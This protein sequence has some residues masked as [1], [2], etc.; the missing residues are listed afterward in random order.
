MI[1]NTSNT[2]KIFKGWLEQRPP[3]M[4]LLDQC[5]RY[6]ISSSFLL[7][8][9]FCWASVPKWTTCY[10]KICAMQKH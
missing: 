1:S 10:E 7:L 6:S 4:S 2:R 8:F 9:F 5:N 3:A